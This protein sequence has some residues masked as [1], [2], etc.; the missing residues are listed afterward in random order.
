MTVSK[1]EIIYSENT[2]NH[3]GM[4][5]YQAKANHDEL[6]EEYEAALN[7]NYQPSADFKNSKDG[8]ISTGNTSGQGSV[9]ATRE[10]MLKTFGAP[11]YQEWDSGDK[12]TIEWE[13]EFVDGTI[14]TIY[15]WK[16]IECGEEP[17]AIGL[18]DPFSW[19]IGGTSPRAVQMVEASLAKTRN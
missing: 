10:E 12:V 5:Y 8:F 3:A 18:F 7:A 13:L 9:I 16:R 6:V 15:D 1:M 11:H 14:A 17:F 4:A 2:M 19:N